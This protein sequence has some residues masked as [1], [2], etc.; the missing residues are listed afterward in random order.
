MNL[1]FQDQLNLN[2][3]FF[4]YQDKLVMFELLVMVLNHNLVE[5]LKYLIKQKNE[6]N[7]NLFS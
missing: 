7:V 6:N 5:E 4:A 2:H 1:L 3:N